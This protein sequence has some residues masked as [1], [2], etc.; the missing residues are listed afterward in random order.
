MPVCARCQGEIVGIIIGFI[1][2]FFIH[3]SIRCLIVLLLPLIIDGTV[4]ALT[5][6]ES[7]NVKR[8]IT[9]IAFGYALV[10]LLV[11]SVTVTFR[12]G[13]SRGVKISGAFN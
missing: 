1:S 13:Y 12:W 7:N 5:D 8:L 4:Q 6:Y 3:L 9:G 2:T 11:I 10:T